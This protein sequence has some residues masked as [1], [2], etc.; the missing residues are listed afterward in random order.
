MRLKKRFTVRFAAE[1]AKSRF[2]HLG[3]LQAA[4]NPRMTQ[5]P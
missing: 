1:P 5:E 4:A 2:D 3:W